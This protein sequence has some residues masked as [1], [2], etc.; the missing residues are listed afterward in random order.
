MGCDDRVKRGPRRHQETI[1]KAIAMA[2][3]FFSFGLAALVSVAAAQGFG[4]S[5]G[6]VPGNTLGTRYPDNSP[7]FPKRTRDQKKALMELNFK[8]LKDHAKALAELSKSLQD[9]I[10]KSNENVLSL[11]IVKKA[12]QAE[13]LAKQIKNEAKGD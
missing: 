11:E 12:E 4:Q 2:V 13:K 6:A 10:E 8:K 7:T 5:E 9:D 1:K 3:V